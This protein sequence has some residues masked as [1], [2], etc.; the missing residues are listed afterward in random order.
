[1]ETTHNEIE[2]G[3]KHIDHLRSKTAKRHIETL[4][5]VSNL[6][7]TQETR[8]WDG[9]S[10]VL[11]VITTDVEYIWTQ[12]LWCLTAGQIAGTF[13]PWCLDSGQTLDTTHTLVHVWGN[14]S[15]CISV[16]F[17]QSY[18]YKVT[19]A[20]FLHCS[21][22]I[23]PVF[24]VTKVFWGQSNLL[25]VFNLIDFRGALFHPDDTTIILQMKFYISPFNVSFSIFCVSSLC[26]L[27][28]LQLSG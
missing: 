10:L 14:D 26:F 16:C 25:T 8:T 1:M 15:R 11:P 28:H 2:T 20:Y 23:A 27:H 7:T 9:V 18:L 13:M 5:M 22:N 4:L 3:G 6:K 24:P 21:Y 19:Q 12:A 17:K